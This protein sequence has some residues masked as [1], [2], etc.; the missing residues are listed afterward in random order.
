MKN[1]IVRAVAGSYILISLLLAI[2]VNQNWLWFATF[3][4]ANL[5]QS[6]ISKWCLMDTILEKLGVK[7]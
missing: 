5:L 4:G 3:V 7:D 2:Y 1:R 6:S